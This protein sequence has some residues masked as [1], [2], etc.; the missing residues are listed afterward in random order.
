MK[1]IL[2]KFF[3]IYLVYKKMIW[4]TV[5][6][7]ALFGFG[8]CYY[9]YF[10]KMR[11]IAENAIV[12]AYVAQNVGLEN[13]GLIFND[14]VEV[15]DLIVKHSINPGEVLRQWCPAN[16]LR[17]WIQEIHPRHL[18]YDD[19]YRVHYVLTKKLCIDYYINHLRIPADLVLNT[20]QRILGELDPYNYGA[21]HESFKAAREAIKIHNITISEIKNII[22]QENKITENAEMT[23]IIG[24]VVCISIVGYA[25]FKMMGF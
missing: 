12:V 9:L 1:M 5:G 6:L 20:H 8:F 25:C 22:S 13:Q 14:I 17:D 21:I 23:L 15:K 2:Q 3:K 18:L 24:T 4:I 7:T 16:H 11:L 10:I 19:L